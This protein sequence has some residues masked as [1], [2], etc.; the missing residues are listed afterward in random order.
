M[1]R[2][3]A[4]CGVVAAIPGLARAQYFGRN[5]VS[6]QTFDFHVMKTDHFDI[7]FYPEE[8]EAVTDLARMAE[9]WNVRHTRELNHPLSDRRALVI[10]ANHPDFQQTNIGG[11]LISEGTGGF[12]EGLRDRVVLPL[13]GVYADNDHVLGHEL[14][15]VW[16]YNIAE[17]PGAT[18][19]QALDRLPL[20]LI[21]GMAE[22]LSLGREDELTAMW[23]RDGVVHKDIPTI[24]Q[25][26][27]SNKYFPY[28]WGQALWAYIGGKW[29]DEMIGRMYR[30]A[31]GVGF[32]SAIRRNLGM[33]SDS[34][35]KEWAA[36]IRATY[37]PLIQG[38]TIAADQGERVLVGPLKY[39]DYNLSPVQSPDGKYVAF[40]GA[41]SL[42]GVDL[43][44]AD[45]HTGKVVHTLAGPGGDS[46]FDAIS[47]IYSAG[48]WSPDGR[49]LA[50]ITFSSGDNEIEIFDLDKGGIVQQIHPK[51]VG[52]ISTVAWSPDG[53]KIA[54]SGIKGGISDLYLYSF[55]DA[56]V[57]QLTDDKYADLQPT[58]SPDGKTIAWVTDRGPGTDFT[59]L[60][61]APMR[62]ATMNLESGAI[63]LLPLFEGV[64]HLNPQFSPDGKDLFFIA[65]REG[66]S[67]L[68]RVSLQSGEI[69]QLTK[70]ATGIFGIS[71]LSPAM[72]VASQTGRIMFSVFDNGGQR[73][74]A[75]E[76]EQ[77]RGTLVTGAP[78][79]TTASLQADA[80]VNTGASAAPTVSSGSGP[81]ADAGVLP[82]VEARGR[83][84]VSAYL[85]D[86]EL[87]LPPAS[88]TYAVTRYKPSLSLE[89]L[90]QPS[91]GV[92]VGG[93]FGTQV[94][95]SASA[96]FGDV[97]GDRQ[98][99]VAVQSGGTA[100]DLGAQV[101]YFNSK[102]RWTYGFGAGRIPYLSGFTAVGQGMN[103]TNCTEIDYVLQRVYID[104]L[105]F[106]VNYPL[107]QTKRW[108]LSVG[109]TRQSFNQEVQAITVDNSTGSVISQ[110]RRNL[111][112]GIYTPATFIEPSIAFV[113]DNSFFGF[114][115][116][117]AGTRYR[118][119]ATPTFGSFNYQSYLA[120]YRR[121]FFQKPF[122]LAFRG[123]HYGRYGPN[124]DTS[125]LYPLYVGAPTLVRGYASESFDPRECT[126]ATQAT[127]TTYGCPVIDR[128][129]GSRIAVL[130]AELRFPLLG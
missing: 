40:Y 127:A 63:K 57:R 32:E 31:L 112:S 111:G 104:E 75:L 105:Q 114:T 69:Y 92:A 110:D 65:A 97:L 126:G 44:V 50:F 38:R 66:F 39:G 54:F 68:Y 71:A 82:P 37:T 70:L 106:A 90:G 20:W 61:Y 26:T 121:Y 77:T 62:L 12:T 76:P 83:G 45:A 8:R 5:K 21:E 11:D 59:K 89:Y 18:G 74:H 67:D 60:T 14:V 52:A 53:G 87:G 19:L 56:S 36:S 24:K 79:A 95:G 15:H 86:P 73:V 1:L 109:A 78:L 98:L 96:F 35:S 25:L 23:M 49:R 99:G 3:A 118:F 88:T 22:Y 10:Y 125:R 16:Q 41:R 55:A 2:L 80:T 102:N 84:S 43:L 51:T 115:S 4:V 81:T 123:M 107:S 124:A 94:A 116:P 101:Q 42:F 33:S 128:L 120:D 64:K 113:G 48:A 103:C 6:Y 58:W 117:I 46:H 91:L 93:G 47:F 28:R 13:T 17:G 119:A 29:G 129:L 7:H 85:R 122:T 72:S 108:E 100:K 9:R 34:L 27:E 30:S 130:N